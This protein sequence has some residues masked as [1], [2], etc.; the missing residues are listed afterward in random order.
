MKRDCYEKR[1]DYITEYRGGRYKVEYLNIVD[2]KDSDSDFRSS[3]YM[4]VVIMSMKAH[5]ID[6]ELQ[7]LMY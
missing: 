3:K 7:Y 5:S 2:S 4:S 1:K 6:N